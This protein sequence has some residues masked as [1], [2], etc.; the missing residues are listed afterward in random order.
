MS[1]RVHTLRSHPD[2]RI[3]RRSLISS[4]LVQVISE[5]KVQGGLRRV[6][7]TQAKRL[8]WLAQRRYEGLDGASSVQVK[9]AKED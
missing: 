7:L 3:V 5:R 8:Q 9:A 4:R 6:L 1:D 2:F